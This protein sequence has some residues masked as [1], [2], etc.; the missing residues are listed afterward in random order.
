M[1]KVEYTVVNSVGQIIAKG[2]NLAF[3]GINHFYLDTELFPVGI[4]AIILRQG[5][6]LSQKLIVKK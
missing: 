6:S 5:S 4:Y 1:T 2:E 3:E